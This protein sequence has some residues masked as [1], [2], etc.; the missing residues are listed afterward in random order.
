MSVKIMGLVWDL[1]IPREEKFILLAYTDHASHD[2]TNIYP[3]VELISQKT[4]YSRRSVQ[5]ITRNLEERGLLLSDGKGPNGTNKWKYG[6]AEIS[7]AKSAQMQE[8][9]KRGA[10]STGKGAQPTAPESSEPSLEPSL[11]DEDDSKS[12]LATLSKLYSENIGPI[13]NGIT[14]DLIRNASIDFP[15]AWYEPAFLIAVKNNA[16]KW[17]YIEAILDSWKKNGFG[18]KPAK[19]SENKQ[20]ESKSAAAIRE[21]AKK[22]GVDVNG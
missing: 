14:A 6:G 20:S 21:F 11:N 18:W 5:T 7:P 10:K 19:R 12:S 22:H 1:D 17:S 2:G 13:P 9:K 15:E 4:G 16:R 8:K 3:S